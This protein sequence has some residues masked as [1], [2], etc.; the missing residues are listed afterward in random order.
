MSR[1]EANVLKMRL[2]DD[3]NCV[4]DCKYFVEGPFVIVKNR[5]IKIHPCVRGVKI[6]LTSMHSLPT[7]HATIHGEYNHHSTIL[8]FASRRHRLISQSLVD[9]NSRTRPSG[10]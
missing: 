4:R 8:L 7:L 9:E 2:T 6:P 1:C 5:C 10:R 3:N